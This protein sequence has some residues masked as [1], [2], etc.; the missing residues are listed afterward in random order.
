MQMQLDF[1]IV[2]SL[3]RPT[4][5]YVLVFKPFQPLLLIITL[6]KIT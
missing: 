4:Q 3:F 5:Y 2:E 6:E 1:E